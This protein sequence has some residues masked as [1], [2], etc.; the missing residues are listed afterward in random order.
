MP[1]LD[2]SQNP[3][4]LPGGREPIPGKEL[5][6]FAWAR[7]WE[8]ERRKSLPEEEVRAIEASEQALDRR[9]NS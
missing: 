1:K 3:Y 2:L 5:E 7:E 4:S 8:L 9:M 6:F